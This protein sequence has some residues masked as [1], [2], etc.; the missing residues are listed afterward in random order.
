MSEPV[1][2]Q[3]FKGPAES[4][5]G[6]RKEINCF[7]GYKVQNVLRD[8]T[9]IFCVFLTVKECR[10]LAWGWGLREG[11]LRCKSAVAKGWGD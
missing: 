5:L 3:G 2:P 6:L 10:V 7:A 4:I 8:E 9:K 1:I 11:A